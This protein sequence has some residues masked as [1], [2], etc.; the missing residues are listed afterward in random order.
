MIRIYKAHINEQTKEIQTIKEHAVGTAQLAQSYGIPALSGVLYQMG[1]LHDCGK[2]QASWQR[3]IDGENIQVEHSI[4]GAKEAWNLYDKN[5]LAYL[6]AYCIAGHHGGLPDGGSILDNSGT[7][8]LNGRLHKE[9]E[10]YSAYKKE[11]EIEK[12]DAASYINFLIS[13][14]DKN[15]P[16]I[17]DQFAFWTRYAYS[18]LVDA[19][20]NDTAHFCGEEEYRGLHADFEKALHLV[21]HKFQSFICETEL[22]KSRAAIQAQV[23]RKIDDDAEVYLM[24][25]PTG[26]GKTLCSVKAALERA[27]KKQ[28]KRIIYIFPF[29]A[30]IDQS[31]QV[32]TDIFGNSLE[33]LRHQST[34]SYEENEDLEEDYRR[35]AKHAVENWDAP[36]IV[37]TAVQFFESVNSNRRGKLRKM[38]NM[39]DSILIFDEAHLMPRNYLQPCLQAVSYITKYLNSEAMFLT[40]TM[41]DF[42]KLFSLYAM[43]ENKICNLIEDK[44]L[45]GKFRKCTYQYEKYLSAE[46][47]LKSIQKEASIL[48]IVNKKK[49]ARELYEMEKGNKYHLSTYMTAWDRENCI[50]RIK[51]EL[52]QLEKD[53]PNGEAVPE[54]RKIRV[55]ATSLVEAGVDFDFMTVY[56]ELTGL[57][58]ILQAGGRCNREGKRKDAVVHI[59]KYEELSGRSA[60]EPDERSSL[61]LGLLDEYEDISCTESILEYYNRYYYVHSEDIQ[62]YA[63]HRFAEDTLGSMDF[64]SIPFREYAEQFKIVESENT[65]SVV[66]PQDET[67]RQIMESIKRTGKGNVRAVQ[68]YV[69]SVSRKEFE[70]LYKQHVVEDFGI[71]IWFLTNTDYYN[72]ETGITFEAKDYIL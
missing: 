26:S 42:E 66:V 19:D 58:S 49:T 37:T 8:T 4:C 36:F 64:R 65:V 39:A 15:L 17:V 43:K 54:N 41:P 40:A 68:R 21:E 6:M 24:N 71:G 47:L 5:L 45:F 53:F 69:C 2:Y 57:D 23:F 18:C 52:L 63:M 20:W 55:F 30:I 9:N 32:F 35:V 12:L 34:F 38:H 7:M 59:F 33:I 1:L 10:D 48:V 51:K 28:K 60:P 27:I 56:R 31:V 11:I 3:R 14:C 22:Q 67:C 13:H 61:T 50:N 44:S 46:G 70:D 62:K 29:N 16:K 25:M 72:R